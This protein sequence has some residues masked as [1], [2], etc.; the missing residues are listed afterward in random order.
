ME[1]VFDIDAPVEAVWELLID[2]MRWPE[3]GPSVNAVDFRDRFIR[4]GTVGRVRIPLGIW[5]P[6]FI[7]DFKPQHYWCWRISEVSATGHIVLPLDADRTRLIF[8]LPCIAFA[9]AVVCRRAGQR[10]A[11]PLK[12]DYK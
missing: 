12:T 9:Y 11:R 2:T 7:T 1:V 5:V 8:K 3:W 6:F 4:S 10:I